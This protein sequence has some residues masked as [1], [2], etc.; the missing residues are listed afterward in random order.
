M[1]FIAAWKQILNVCGMGS[2]LRG[3]AAIHKKKNTTNMR[4]GQAMG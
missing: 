4:I 2:F 1:G 3:K